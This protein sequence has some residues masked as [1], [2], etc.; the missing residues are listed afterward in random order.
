MEI[1][2]IIFLFIPDFA[3]IYWIG[4]FNIQAIT[5]AMKNGIKTGKMYF[6]KHRIPARIIAQYKN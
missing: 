5:K 1:K 4:F 2:A 3:E 6:P